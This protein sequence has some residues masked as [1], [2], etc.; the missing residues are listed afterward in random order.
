MSE[1]QKT[2]DVALSFAGEDRAYVELVAES[3]KRKGVR[4][5]YDKFE[6]VDLWGKNLYEHLSDVYL[7]SAR[8]TVMFISQYYAAKVWTNH[9]RRAAQARA[10]N[11]AREYILPARFDGTEIPGL[12]DTTAYLDLRTHSPE[13]IAIRLA[14][15][16]GLSLGNLKES[17]VP[18]LGR[19]DEEGEV[20]FDYTSYNGAYRIGSGLF[21]FETKWSAASDTCVHCYNDGASVAGIA[22]LKGA[23]EI[24][25]VRDAR[26]CDMTSRARMVCTGEIVVLKNVNGF[27][28]ALKILSVRNERTGH[29]RNELRFYYRI[30]RGGGHDF[31]ARH[32]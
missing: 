30:L 9:E 1:N 5:F 6:E 12:L 17:S 3:L 8:F 24:P 28:A 14:R 32:S 31:D 13:E 20:T 19:L 26:T 18:P 15:K 29:D 25:D 10:I 7:K 16:L 4:V 2:Y 21:E 23:T 11:E 27:F 22:I